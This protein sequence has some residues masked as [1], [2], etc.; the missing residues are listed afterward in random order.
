MATFRIRQWHSYLSLFAAPSILFFALTGSV[1]LFGLHESHGA[2]HPAELVEKLAKVH[3][4][5]VFAARHR[6]APAAAVPDVAQ[7]GA[8][9][10][11]PTDEEEDRTP[12]ATLALKVFFLAVSLCLAVSASL[13]IWIGLTQSRQKGLARLLVGA[14]AVVPLALLLLA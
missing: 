11:G 8:A 7:R 10:H 14:G 12:P 1:Q 2:Y 13:G 5:Q 4:D 3:K 6:P 9:P